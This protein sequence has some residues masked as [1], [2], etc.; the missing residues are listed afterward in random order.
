MSEHDLLLQAE[1]LSGVGGF[2]LSAAGDLHWTPQAFR[3]HGLDP[4]G[5]QPSWPQWLAWLG[6]ADRVA[7]ARALQP[8]SEPLAQGV[9]HCVLHAAD[10]RHGPLRLQAR[11]DASAAPAG[12]WLGT[13]QALAPAVPHDAAAGRPAAI[14]AAAEPEA[15]QFHEPLAYAVSAAGVG[16]WEMDVLTGAEVWS[17][18]TLAFYGLP[19]GSPAP[20]R[21]RWRREFLHPDDHARV[22]ERA[23]EMES[24]G[25]PYEMDYR[26]RRAGDGA[27]RWLHSRATFAFGGRRRVLGVTLDITERRL[28]ED[29]A[30]EAARQLD[31]AATHIGFGFGHRSES[32]VAGV[33]SPQ[34]KQ[35]FGLAVDAPTPDSDGLL[36]LVA[37]HDRVR[38]QQWLTTPMQAGRI[39]EFEFEL[40]P[41]SRG[42]PGDRPSGDRQPGDDDGTG[43]GARIL[44]AR[45]VT[46]ADGPDRQ[47]RTDFALVD[48]TAL[49]RRDRQLSRLLQ[50]LQ[51]AT[52]AGGVGTW[53]RDDVSG[54]VRW[55]ELTLRL[56]GLAPGTPAPDYERYLELVH[57][58]DR[59]RMRAEWG[60]VQESAVSVDIE[61]RVVQPAGAVR[62]LRSLGRIERDADGRP[63]RRLGI[64]F[65]TTAR[66]EAEAAL[67]ARSVAEQ[68][69][70]AKT[71]FL[72][73]M[74]HELR[75]PL[76]AVLGF[77]Q[78]L[79]LDQQEPLLPAQRMRVEHIQAAGWHLLALVND[80]LDL[81][82][83]ES[84]QATLELQ[85]VAL[86]EVVQECL[87]MS[88]PAAAAAR[89][90]LVWQPAPALPGAVWADR[91]RLRQVLLN[92]LSNGIKYNR[93]GGRVLVTARMGDTLDA[94]DAGGVP[95]DGVHVPG[96]HV[97]GVQ[98]GAPG[99]LHLDV[100]DTGLGLDA[101]QM[102][103]LFEPFN[104][105]GRERSA[106]EGSGIGLALSKLLV[107]QMGGGVQAC[108]EPGHGTVLRVTLRL[109]PA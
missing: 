98:A 108:S 32:G 51:L 68:A 54:D 74:S 90:T 27:L 17:E 103:Q 83:I 101:A 6:E 9:L 61:F 75:T 93:A 69:N 102:Q 43:T 50:H 76:N 19:P 80:V 20:S 56:F 106:I 16:V 15:L 40:L 44:M 94:P 81:S 59:E 72:S 99:W 97:P 57:P 70:A 8:G 86:D 31:L 62:W 45:A 34:L 87:A 7:L 46:V 85:A 1:S 82:R 12:R 33:W 24:S 91:T 23:A 30:R 14:A 55:D 42:E 105:L 5:P 89:V 60:R 64:C 84:R 26:I 88:A 10:A 49:R 67:Q 39:S 2:S 79:G 18:L 48:V 65:D 100:C 71:E 92:L 11:W 107:E 41:P 38:V 52:E 4:A 58:D 96:V 95:A 36:A 37:P 28:A 21:E 109:P 73:R 78:L 47:P 35:L 66:R 53:E 22:A 77:A 25:R 13:V 104:R 3:L 63:R 29:A